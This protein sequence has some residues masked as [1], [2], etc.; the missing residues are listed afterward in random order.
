M[1]KIIPMTRNSSE[2]I[3]R[4]KALSCTCIQHRTLA[5]ALAEI[6]RITPA[7]ILL[8]LGLPDANTLEAV[9]RLRVVAPDVAIVLLSGREN[10][11]LAISALQHGVQD[12]RCKD[13]VDGRSLLRAL[14]YR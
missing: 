7:L 4:G 11:E 8:D 1:L 12:Y 14:R 6:K 13:R 9:H 5:D 3:Y 10:E 2:D